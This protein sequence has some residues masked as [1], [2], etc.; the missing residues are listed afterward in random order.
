MRPEEDWIVTENAHPAIISK[1]LW[2]RVKE[3]EKSVS[4]G[5]KTRTGLVHP[6]SGFMYCADCG[7]KMKLELLFLKEE[8][9]KK[10]YGLYV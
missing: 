10:R 2:D 7:S 1:E 6:L 3:V 9:H 8:R 4:Q 5:K